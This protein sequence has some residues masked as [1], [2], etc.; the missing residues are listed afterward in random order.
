VTAALV[1]FD[2]AWFREQM[3]TVICPYARLQS[4]LLDKRSLIV[5]YDARHGEPRAKGKPRADRGDCIDCGA[6]V[7]ACP[8]GIDIRDGLQLECI[9]CAQCVD[10]CDSIMDRIVKPRVLIRYGSQDELET[11][12]PSPW[13]RPRV[14][15]YPLLLIGLVALLLVVGKS[16]TA[17]EVT[18]LRGQGAP[19]VM[20]GELVQNQIRIKIQNRSSSGRSYTLSLAGLDGAR[21]IAPENPLRVA[22]EARAETSVF[23]L[24]PRSA[25]SAGS[26]DVSFVVKDESGTTTTSGYRLLGPQ[27]AP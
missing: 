5:G 23:V 16:R 25:F 27:E 15:V 4:V 1:M 26:R 21:L 10:A 14:I 3:C 22:A 7:R 2:F 19:F 9:A 8:T 13:L 6:C 24:A 11:G 18:I 20:Q 17:D 12:Q